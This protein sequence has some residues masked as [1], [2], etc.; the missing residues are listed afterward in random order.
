MTI[1][2]T[3]DA[4]D[5]TIDETADLAAETTEAT[6]DTV[7]DEAL[8]EAMD[9]ML[10][11][12]TPA[13][14]AADEA[15]TVEAELIDPTDE[16]DL[17]DSPFNEDISLEE[18]IQRLLNVI[19]G[20]PLDGMD[21]LGLDFDLGLEDDDDDASDSSDMSGSIDAKRRA[22]IEAF[23]RELGM[24]SGDDGIPSDMVSDLM[25]GL[26][27]AEQ[28]FMM[29]SQPD[30]P[31][32]DPSDLETW[33]NGEMPNHTVLDLVKTDDTTWLMWGARFAMESSTVELHIPSP[34]L[35]SVKLNTH[36]LPNEERIAD[37]TMF[38][39]GHNGQFRLC[40]FDKPQLGQPITFSFTLRP[41]SA[42]KVVESV[43]TTLMCVN[44]YMND[45][46][47]VNYGASA[48]K[49]LDD[50]ND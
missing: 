9:E 36:L 47:L 18:R 48:M 40:G 28:R 14:G 12:E 37:L 33:L 43:K 16:D 15:V 29:G 32:E 42:L 30:V 45:L 7:L 25:A 22:D 38:L 50:D 6:V 3:I 17:D 35:L 1:L 10:G 41:T 23:M 2:Q 46:L 44:K 31:F 21:E 5:M 4:I 24:D 8:A 49:M 26:E 39:M 19:G 34:G 27:G 11:G 13:E 20:D